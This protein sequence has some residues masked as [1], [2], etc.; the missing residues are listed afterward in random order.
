MEGKDYLAIQNAIIEIGVKLQV[1]DLEEFIR[2][3]GRAELMAP[4]LDPV[5]FRKASHNLASLKK[6]ATML[7]PA[8]ECFVEVQNAIIM[9]S[10]TL[11]FSEKIIR[12]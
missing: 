10:G 4:A 9:K 8:K 5:L 3:M 7:I 11:G 2:V 12:P 1:L 6:L